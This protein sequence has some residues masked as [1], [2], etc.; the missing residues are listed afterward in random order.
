MGLVV[1]LMGIY[2]DELLPS[3]MLIEIHSIQLTLNHLPA[4]LLLILLG[5]LS[6]YFVVPMNALLQHRGHALMSTGQS[7]AAQGFSENLAI[8]FMLLIYSI[9]LWLNLSLTLII[10]G[11][12]LSVFLVMILIMYGNLK[13]SVQELN[14]HKTLTH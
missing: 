3:I 8:L 4:Y 11:F 6:G 9:L 7:I 10:L 1:C 2:N 5:W 12:G 13:M 14:T